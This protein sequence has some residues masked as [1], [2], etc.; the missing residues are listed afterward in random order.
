MKRS[1]LIVCL[2]IFAIA[3]PA[4]AQQFYED[5]VYLKDG[6]I[7]RGV[8]VEQI[9]GE[10][11]KV[12]LQGGSVMVFKMS[13]VLK[14]AK[15][16]PLRQIPKQRI[17]S[18]QTAMLLSFFILGSGQVYNGEI[19]KAAVHWLTGFLTLA[20][21]MSARDNG[22]DGTAGFMGFLFLGNWV[23]SIY[24]AYDT[25]RRINA[26]HQYQT[27]LSISDDRVLVQPYSAHNFYHADNLFYPH[28]F[29]HAH[30]RPPPFPESKG[31]VLS[32]K[33]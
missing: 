3:A 17:K 19:H 18:P 8:I 30:D 20:I 1:M 24:D 28:D 23:Y 27:G 29:S 15:E 9:P 7:I 14:I 5:V 13:N 11:L 10:S 26:E 32:L 2:L 33:F 25:A 16:P 6:S 4:A 22:N 21:G 12:Q 31:I